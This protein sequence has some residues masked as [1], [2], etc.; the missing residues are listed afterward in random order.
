MAAQLVGLAHPVDSH[1]EA[2]VSGTA[3][4]HPGKRVFEH[5]RRGRLD[6]EQLRSSEEGV[7]GRFAR[8]VLLTQG[9][10]VDPLS[11]KSV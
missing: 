6:V 1:D 4:L 11:N 2:E 10:T 9:H 7:R 8:E 5:R 3:G